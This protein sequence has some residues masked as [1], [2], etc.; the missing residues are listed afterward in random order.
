MLFSLPLGG[1]GVAATQLIK[2]VPDTTIFGTCSA[3]KH[4]TVK[5]FGVQYPIDYRT[6]DYV[7]EVRKVSPEGEVTF[8]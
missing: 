1:V 2:S 6:Q 3:A 4:E 5:G 7:T 8:D